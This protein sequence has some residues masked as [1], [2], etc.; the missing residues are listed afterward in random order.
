MP[1]GA[2]SGR[3]FR[4]LV[5]LTASPAIL[6]LS[7]R[8]EASV[9]PGPAMTSRRN[10]KTAPPPTAGE[11]SAP[12]DL[13][14]SEDLFGDL[15]DESPSPSSA[16]KPAPSAAGGSSVSSSPPRKGPIKV[17]VAEPGAARKASPLATP[18]Q[19]G[20]KLPE[21]VAALLDAFSEPAESLLREN[22]ELD[23][24]PPE[25][26]ALDLLAD[27]PPSITPADEGDDLLGVLQSL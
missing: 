24:A 10:D 19:T 1:I 15:V 21:D 16:R 8:R 3:N 9:S 23:T 2:V 7:P 12:N 5:D 13:L 11:E 17:Q 22:A 14:T 26:G 27:E 20:E 4:Q 25:A 18:R 6:P